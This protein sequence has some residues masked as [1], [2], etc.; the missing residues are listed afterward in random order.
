MI[1]ENMSKKKFGGRFIHIGLENAAVIRGV[2]NVD[3]YKTFARIII[4]AS[5]ETTDPDDAFTSLLRRQNPVEQALFGENKEEDVDIYIYIYIK[6]N[7]IYVYMYPKHNYFISFYAQSR[8]IRNR[9][10]CR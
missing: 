1:F 4:R 3:V 5:S 10:K 9:G 8:T 2:K 6:C 7:Q